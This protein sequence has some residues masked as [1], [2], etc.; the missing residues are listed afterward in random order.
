MN[1]T[2]ILDF[3]SLWVIELDNVD[4]GKHRVIWIDKNGNAHTSIGITLR[5]AIIGAKLE[6]D[7]MFGA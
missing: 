4:D 5:D 1:D 6:M 2:Q 3:I 7:S